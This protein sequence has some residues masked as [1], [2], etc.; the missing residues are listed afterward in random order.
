MKN[1]AP[2]SPVHRRFA[3][4]ALMFG[5]LVTGSTILAP[6]GMLIELSSDLGVTV[7]TAGLLITF[8]AIMLCVGSP[9]T[10]WLT[11]RIERRI[12][13][14]VTIAVL[15][16]GNAASALAPGYTTLLVLRLV[17][18]AIGA[19]YTPQAA[20]T[21]ALIVPAE[22]RGG[23]IA[24]VFLGWSLAA[25][26]GLPLITF[27][28]SR[29]GWRAAYGGISVIGALSFLLLLW[30]LPGGLRGAAVD[31]KTWADLGRNRVIIV[32]LAITTLLM[33]G[34]FAVFTYM[35][36]VLSRLGQVGAD[37][38]G[39]VFAVYGACGFVG[40]VVVSNIVDSW[41]PLKTSMLCI[42]LVLAGV[43]GW[44]FTAGFYPLMAGSAA[45]W[46]LGFASSNSMQQ[47]R[48]VAAAPQLASASVSLNT[49]FLYVGQA[50]GSGIGGLLYAHELLYGIG[51]AG[52]VFVA[53]ALITV[54]MTRNLKTS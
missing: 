17:M 28:A 46:G 13:L 37:A 40:I 12:L 10:A 7:H 14:T 5:N 18:L 38:V 52:A 36:P 34:Q 50:I 20:G 45:I 44:A 11:S 24:Y 15:T 23:T 31:L 53:L 21:A 43:A 30:R 29:Y 4:T 25:A 32:L 2:D 47:V 54:I 35:G 19:L 39:L 27:M 9:L 41:G 6:A 33:S 26:I 1:L 51:Y 42:S 8:G 16:L 3:P 22:K 48:L 49:S